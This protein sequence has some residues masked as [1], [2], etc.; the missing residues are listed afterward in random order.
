M[1]AA[2]G[3]SWTASE[4][5]SWISITS[6]GS[7]GNGTVSYSV[8]ANTSTGSRSGTITIAG[9]TFTVTQAGVPCSYS[10]S[11]ASQSFTSSGG[12]GSVSV[13]A[14]SGCSWTTAESLSWITITSGSSGSGNGTVS[15][16][17][18]AN[19]STSS[20]S[21]TITIAGKTFIV[22]QEIPVFSVTPSMKM[23]SGSQ[24]YYCGKEI[25][26]SAEVMNPGGCDYT[27]TWYAN[28]EIIGYGENFVRPLELSGEVCIECQYRIINCPG[29][30][31]F[32]PVQ[33]ICTVFDDYYCSI[34]FVDPGHCSYSMSLITESF[35]S[36]GGTGSRN[37]TKDPFCPSLYE[38]CP[39]AA[40]S[41]SNWL[42]VTSGSSGIGNIAVTYSVDPYSGTSPRIG[43]INIKTVDGII[44]TK[45]IQYGSPDIVYFPDKN[46]ENAI[47]EAINKPEGSITGSDLQN[48]TYLDASNRNITNLEGLQRCSNLRE[49][50]L[51]Q[52][53]IN[54]ISP[55]A[56]LTSMS[57]LS[58]GFNQITD[59][60]PIEG[61]DLS[62]LD[63]QHN[64]LKDI[65]PVE[66]LKTRCYIIWL[67][68]NQINDIYP[69]V[70]L[71]T[72]SP[73]ICIYCDFTV[74]LESNSLNTNS[75]NSYVSQL[76]NRGITVYHDC[77]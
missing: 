42:T 38:N 57:I 46:L 67:S 59:I 37:I 17:V 16:S 69:L 61:L 4:N 35:D 73:P 62:F 14:A 40:K 2:S 26:F 47:R 1:T 68:S 31:D 6:G 70:L 63:L 64:Q 15:Y 53:Q 65:S 56:G 76:E 43:M 13:T 45:I 12:T 18:S 50:F 34:P 54:S 39:W 58:L 36:S 21:G 3:C 48:L 66:W 44:A 29:A 77:P 23:V 32:K 72:D 8:S 20:R 49:L 22:T 51:F 25:L 30:T 28:D 11:P 27:L 75:C 41:N 24:E 10:I 9:K 60:T 7:S 71:Y 74:T 52:N 19:T 5:L 33:K 55:L